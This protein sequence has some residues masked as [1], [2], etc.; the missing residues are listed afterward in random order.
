MSKEST[1]EFNKIP[2]LLGGEAGSADYRVEYIDGDINPTDN[3][4]LIY[5]DNYVVIG[6]KNDIYNKN[7]DLKGLTLGVQNADSSMISYYLKTVN[8]IVYKTYET[9]EG[10][11]KAL[12]DNEV[13]AVVVPNIINLDKTVNGK[14]YVNY[15]FNDI[16][17]K[18]VITLSDKNDK[19]NNIFKKTFNKWIKD[20]YSDDYN[21]ILLSYYIKEN[22][23]NIK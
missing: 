5:E 20:K 4:L 7:S 22:N 3:Q 10:L 18:L 16:S 11:F 17:K 14:Y 8:S 21:E 6:K 9:T 13:N 12:E 19:L 15:F 1:L 2:Y 23:I